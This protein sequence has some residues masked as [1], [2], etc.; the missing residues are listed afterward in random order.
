[1][2]IPAC[3]ILSSLPTTKTIQFPGGATLS[4]IVAAGT[5][6]PDALDAATNLLSQT[7]AAL[8]PLIPVLDLLET[9][10]ALVDCV[11]AIPAA[12]G[13][14]PDPT[15]VADCIPTLSEK[16]GKLLALVPQLSLPNLIVDVLDCA[17][18]YL[19][20]VRDTLETI[21]A[22]SAALASAQERAGELGDANLASIVACASENLSI[23]LVAINQ[24]GA[25]PL[26]LFADLTAQKASPGG[27]E[28]FS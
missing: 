14:P 13:P 28:N 27:V 12:L 2:T 16:A 24:S 23:Q 10:L 26:R 19:A 18:Q 9:I 11:K 7:N 22:K 21:I 17:V 1:M 4:Q 6:I 8:S 5:Q 25:E 20:G 3:T 15:G